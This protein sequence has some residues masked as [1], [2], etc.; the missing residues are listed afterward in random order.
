MSFLIIVSSWIEFGV[1][2]KFDDQKNLMKGYEQIF[3]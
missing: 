3:F 1:F 2:R